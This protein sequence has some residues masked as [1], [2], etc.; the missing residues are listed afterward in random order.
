MGL[1]VQRTTYSVVLIVL[2]AFS[3]GSIYMTRRR[4]NVPWVDAGNAMLL[5]GALW[6]AAT[7]LSLVAAGSQTE[8]LWDR[9]QPY[10]PLIFAVIGLALVWGLTLLRKQDLA[11]V[12][13]RLVVDEQ[14]DAVLVLD[15]Q[16]CIVRVND[17]CR[18]LIDPAPAR[19][20]GMPLT[21]VWPVW[22]AQA[23]TLHDGETQMEMTLESE[24][25]HAY[26]VCISP[27]TDGRGR[28]LGRVATLRDVSDLKRAEEENRQLYDQLL[29]ARKMEAIGTLSGGIAHDFNNLL[30]AIQGNATLAKSAIDPDT[31]VYY[32]LTEIEL[33]CRRASRLTHQLLLFSR[34][35]SVQT[36]ALCLNTVIDELLEMLK[37]LIGEDVEVSVSC[38]PD[39]WMVQVDKGSIEQMITNLVVNARDAMPH[40][41]KI[42]IETRNVV[43]SQVH[44]QAMPEAHPGKYVYLSVADE[45]MGM[46]QKV[47][48]RIFEPFF[49]TKEAGK[50]TGLGLTLVHRIVSQHKGWI[51]VDSELDQG[52]TFGVYLPALWEAPEKEPVQEGISLHGLKGRG[53]R[54]LLVEDEKSVREFSAKVLGQHGYVVVDAPDVQSAIDALEHEKW[55]FDLVFSDVVL[56][57]R[58]GLELADQIRSYD[59]AFP[60]LLSSGYTG[61]RSRWEAIR[62]RGFNF[63]QKPY[64]LTDLLGAVRDAIERT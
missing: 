32:D 11:D 29:Q 1:D 46:D 43:L 22:T 4:R 27:V 37:R 17:A 38:A 10:A 25:P 61:Q 40:G 49:S 60:I 31:P 48:D 14:A 15:A 64:T 47:V 12:A 39:L 2:S 63:L 62:E 7:A 51:Q 18:R 35:Q 55:Q 21:E 59:A 6:A 3:I 44:E 9:V 54:I 13:Q 26:R 19:L 28:T 23:G 20:D 45:G 24:T 56:P 50:G 42:A 52:S 33:A 58:S 16:N 5:I 34:K 41:G 57:D 36:E 8:T 30:T 53:E